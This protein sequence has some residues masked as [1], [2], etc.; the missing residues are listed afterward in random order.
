V[1][2]LGGDSSKIDKND[3]WES[4]GKKFLDLIPKAMKYF[5]EAEAGEPAL[6]A[7]LLVQ[8]C[9]APQ[10]WYDKNFGS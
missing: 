8:G 7:R 6:A 9:N 3:C 10:E 4:L 2:S 1:N 5:G